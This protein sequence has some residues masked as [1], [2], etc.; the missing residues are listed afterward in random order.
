[1]FGQY[2]LH[3]YRALANAGRLA[4]H[5]GMAVDLYEKAKARLA[6]ESGRLSIN[7]AA[8]VRFALAFPNVYSVGMA[9]LG[10]QLVYQMLNSLPN[11]SCERVFLPDD[12]DLE[13]HER[14]QTEVF[15]LESLRPLSEF[16]VLGFSISFELDY[17]NV[18]KIIKLGNLPVLS[19]ER[20]DYDPIVIAGGPCASFNPEPLSDFIDVFVI[21]DAEEALPEMVNAIERTLGKPRLQR[22]EALAGVAGVYIPILNNKASRAIARDLDIYPAASLIHAD[23]AQFG[24]ISLVEISRGCGRKCRFCLAGHITR[25]P[26]PRLLSEAQIRGKSRMGLVGAAVFDHP[27]SINIC[28]SIVNSGGEFTVS[29]LRL[30]TVTPELAGLMASG[31]Q[32]TLTIAPE[33]ATDRLRK[34]INKYSTDEQ[35]FTAISIAYESGFRRV[36]LYFMIGLPTET[37]DDI[38]AIIDLTKRVSR[39]YP[40]MQFQVSASSFVPKPWTPFQWHVMERENVLK[41]RYAMLRSGISSIKNAQFG[42]ESP[43]L[44]SVQGYLARGDR[45]LGRVLLTALENGGDYGA[46]LRETG[47]DASQ[48][49]YRERSVEEILPWD[50]LDMAVDKNYLWREYE[51]S[52]EGKLSE[53][54]NV[55]GCQACGACK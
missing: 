31:G 27:D 35:I 9:S 46:A 33:A 39:E 42:G 43:R 7:G 23:D 52:L 4:Y 5:V 19:S 55:G 38:A 40:S 30:E 44:A 51:K 47:V 45:S 25:P 48:Y 10:Y 12:G 6:K 36:K 16:H 24:D 15:T 49:L 32:R 54:C 28:R 13:E 18:L 41:K 50:H 14:T 20:G 8:A 37:N 17:I 53:P 3:N 1:M 22:L 11:A 29:S 21:G 2:C 34:A 26:R